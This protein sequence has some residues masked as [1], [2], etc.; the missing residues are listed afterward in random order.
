MPAKPWEYRSRSPWQRLPIITGGVLVNFILAMI[1]YSAVLF[2]WGEEYVPLQNAK[3]GLSFSKT[4]QEAGFR[5]GDVIK[6]VDGKTVETRGDAIQKILIDNAKTVTVQRND[7]EVNISVPA[8]LSQKIM[9]SGESN[10]LDMQYPFV[11]NEISG[12]SP[13]ALAQL[14]KGDSIVSI[15]GKAV[16]MFQDIAEVLNGSKNQLIKVGFVRNRA[17]QTVDVQ[18]DDKG[19]L[20]VSL[21]SPDNYFQT[22]K[23]SYNLLQ[24]IPAGIKMGWETL[25]GYVKQLK[26]VFTKE[27]SKQLGGFGTIGK[28]FPPIW[29]WQ[30]FWLM[31]AFLS[32][33]LAFMNLLPIPGLDGGYVLF[34]I[35]EIITGKKPSEKFMEISVTVGMVL[36]FALMI[37]ANG[38]DIFKGLFK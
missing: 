12:G 7:S 6:F 36:L 25:A 4:M 14:Q 22:K 33:I 10:L 5:N 2:T 29:D 31:T 26:L 19:K 17:L 34:I 23:T 18:L 16:S 9:A 21:K 20:G 24:S 32:V 1:I 30:S 13:A 15:N 35:Y 37:Y 8:D 38:N 28:L 3:Y 27:G 11:L